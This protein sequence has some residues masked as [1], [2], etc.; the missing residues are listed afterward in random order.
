MNRWAL[1]L[2]P[3][4]AVSVGVGLFISGSTSA[5]SWTAGV[6][7]LCATWWIF[8]PIPIPATSLIPLAV[9]PLVGVLTPSEVGEAYGDKLILL[10]LGGLMLSSAMERSGAHRRIALSMVSLFGGTNGRRLVLGFMAASACLSMWISNMATTL[11]LLPIVVAVLEK[12]EEKQ[13]QRALLLGVAYAASVGGVGTPVG[14]PPNL[15][16]LD[17]Y[18]RVTGTELAFSD[19]MLL[20]L[21]VVVVMIPLTGCWL[22]RGLKQQT[23]IKLPPVG[24]W[25]TEE[26][27]TLSVF[28]LTALLWI[29]RNEPSGGWSN[30]LQL[31]NANDASV[32]LAAVVLMFLI[33][34]G[35]GEHLL[36][37]DT[38]CSIPWGILILF[39]SGIVISKAFVSSGLSDSLGA[40]LAGIGQLPT[41]L[42]IALVCLSVTFLTEVTSNTATSNLLMPVLAAAAISAEIEPKLIM[43]PATISASFAFMLPV[44]TG[45][46]AI[47]FSSGELTVREMA[48][49]GLALNLIG[50]V[51][52]SLVCYLQFS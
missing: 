29:T 18:K 7:L 36:D 6:T 15:I 41:L 25:R 45:P 27:R 32:A 43:V 31:P 23:A 39:S 35:R 10:L 20:A 3:L 46:N 13:L 40:A 30:L 12:V 22:T 11:M 9:F 4:L 47:V 2:G 34:N 28:A 17:N 14:T 8:E 52:V 19:W 42:M 1:I 44:A 33:P 48:R 21:P 37:W 38:A 16:F 24:R 26:I 5:V 50:V 49:E 51:V